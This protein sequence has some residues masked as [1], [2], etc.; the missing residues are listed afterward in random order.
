MADIAEINLSVLKQD[1]NSAVLLLNENRYK[2][3]SNERDTNIIRLYVNE[4]S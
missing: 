2:L 4:E 1:K 3:L